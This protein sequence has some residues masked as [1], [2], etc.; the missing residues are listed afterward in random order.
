VQRLQNLQ[1]ERVCAPKKNCESFPMFFVVWPKWWEGERYP[2]FV[3]EGRCI[4]DGRSS[5]SASIDGK[6]KK[7]EGEAKKKRRTRW[8]GLHTLMAAFETF[9]DFEVLCTFTIGREE[10]CNSDRSA[11]LLEA[12]RNS[13]QLF[14]IN[15]AAFHW[16][17]F[18]WRPLECFSCPFIAPICFALFLFLSLSI[19]LPFTHHIDLFW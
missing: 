15:W 16:P 5:S 12:N 13:W 19:S 6:K 17:L 8:E 9:N 18:A 2:A 14:I 10:K 4:A 3:V 1:W 7:S 11:W